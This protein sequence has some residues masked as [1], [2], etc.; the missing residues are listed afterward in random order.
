MKTKLFITTMLAMFMFGASFAQTLN[1]QGRTNKISTSAPN[2]YEK[3][4]GFSDA[5]LRGALDALVY[6]DF[7]TETDFVVPALTAQG[8]NVTVATGWS[9]FDTKL[10]SGNYGMA[11]AFVQGNAPHPSLPVIQNFIDDDGCMIYCDW[12][13]DN[14][15]A[16]VFESSFTGSNNQN[17]VTIIDA[18]LATGLTNPFTL[19]NPGWGIYSTGLN[20]IGSGEVLATFENGNA[21]IVRGNSGHTIMLGYLSDTP[22]FAMRQ[23]LFEN[24][25]NS[26][27][28]GPNPAVPVSN[29]ALYIGIFLILTFTVI[30]FRKMI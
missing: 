6:V 22:P 13:S 10:A 30:R 28:C 29:W 14:T 4:Y 23:P 9:D 17:T 21:A 16:A 20:A 8:F 18:G 25:I 3:L 1:Q 7:A 19:G 5:T 11:V 12:T 26:T 24:V 2:F 15:Y 27:I